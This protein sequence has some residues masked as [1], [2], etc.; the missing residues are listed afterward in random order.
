MTDSKTI[1][2]SI[3]ALALL[4]ACSNPTGP[5][6]GYSIL[7]V[8]SA[9]HLATCDGSLNQP[10]QCFGENWTANDSAHLAGGWGAPASGWQNIPPMGNWCVHIPRTV[11]VVL[12]M[13]VSAAPGANNF[14]Q[15]YVHLSSAAPSWTSSGTAATP[16]PAC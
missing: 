15:S 2:R 11:P 5:T 4:A 16:G 8:N 7:I 3:F 12:L 10:A 9:A 13:N 14:R 6:D 1:E